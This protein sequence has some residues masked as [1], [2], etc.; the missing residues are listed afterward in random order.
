[1]T[2]SVVRGASCV[3]LVFALACQ[4]RAGDGGAAAREFKGTTAFS[5]VEKQ[6]SF[7]PR[8][9]N[10]PGHDKMGDWLLAEL[11]TRADTVIV[12]DF[13]QRTRKGQT[14]KLRNFFARFRP[15]APDR[16]LFLAHWDTRPFAIRV[17]TS[18]SSACLS[19]VPTTARPGWRCS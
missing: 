15:Q 8:I 13:Q 5:Y 19:P 1:M 17:R 11:R 6:M 3:G 12:Q 7:G 9:P 4:A 2:S 16:I 14:L 10:T 18:P